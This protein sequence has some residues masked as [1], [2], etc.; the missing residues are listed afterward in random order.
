MARDAMIQAAFNKVV[1]D[2]IPARKSYVSLYM[3][4]PFYG[5]PEEGGWWGSDF[6]LVASREYSNQVQAEAALE[7]VEQLAKEMS[8]EARN[9][10]N[11]ACAAQCEWVEQHDPMADVS[12]YFPEVDGEV[13]YQ[14]LIE[15]YP[16]ECEY[17][18][19]RN[20]E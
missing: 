3:R 4:S 16:G 19:S 12:D 6:E 1:A 14:V 5:G 2:A 13:D 8:E 20:Y 10:Y 15:N 11:R 7:R 18:S 9:D 17:H